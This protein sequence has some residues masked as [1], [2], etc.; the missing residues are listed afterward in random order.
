MRLKYI[1]ILIL[2]ALLVF[3]VVQMMRFESSIRE[4]RKVTLYV[5]DDKK[6]LITSLSE[7]EIRNAALK[8]EYYFMAGKDYFSQQLTRFKDGEKK[9]SWEDFF[10]KGVNLGVAVPGK[11]PGEFSLTFDEY[12]SWLK[13]IGEMNANVIRTY[14]ILPPAFYQAL[15]CYNFRHSD[16]P[17]YLMQGV[18]AE[19]PTDE[20]YYNP[21][22]TREFQKEIIDAV[23]VIHGKDVLKELPGKA[24][25]VYA[26][27]V[28]RYVVAILLGREWEPKS[29]FKTNQLNHVR[30]YKGEF[31][32][33]NEGNAVEAW[34]A[35][36]MDFTVLYETQTY[37]FQHPV[38]FVN[39]LPLDPMYHSTEIIENPKIREYDND[40]ESIDFSRFHA[41]E[42]FTPGIFAAYHAY[43]YYPDFVYL[44]PSYLEITGSDNRPDPYLGYLNDLKAH[45]PGMPL[46]IAEYGLPSSRGNSHFS[47]YGM[48]QGGHSEAEQAR[49]SL[50][51]TDDIVKSGCAGAVYFEWIDEWFKQNWLVMDFE[52]PAD[53]RRMWHN[54]ENPEQNFGILAMEDKK[55]KIDGKLN[56]WMPENQAGDKI[57]IMTDADVTYFYLA[58]NI[59]GL[60]FSRKNLYLALDTYDEEKGDHKLPFTKEKFDNG[61]EFLLEFKSADSAAILVD[62]P[63]SVYTDIYNDRIPGYASVKNENGVFIR[64]KMLTNRGRVS[65]LG[66]ITDSVAA[67]RSRLVHGISC[68]PEKSNADWYFNKEKGILEIR[69]DWHLINVTDPAKR[70]VLDN[71]P[72]TSDIEYV[73]SDAFNLFIFLTDKK[74]KLLLKYPE[75]APFSCTWDEWKTPK[76]SSRLKPVYYA[77]QRYFRKLNVPVVRDI[78]D[79]KLQESFSITDFMNGKKK[80]VSI[81][82]DN[83]GYSQYTYA[84]PILGKY[85]L[86]ATFGID[87]EMLKDAPGLVRRDD[88]GTLKRLGLSEVRE[89]AATNE[90]A[91]QF[92]GRAAVTAGAVPLLG[93][94]SHSAIRTMNG[95]RGIQF[96]ALPR[97]ILFYREKP[98]DGLLKSSFDGIPYTAI[99]AGMTVTSLD[100]ILSDEKDLWAILIYHHIYEQP[101]EIPRQVNAAINRKLFLPRAEMEKQI[102]LI[103]NRNYWIAPEGDVY[104]YLKEKKAATIRTER[105]KN[106]I[107]LKVNHSLDRD[108]YDLPLTIEYKTNARIIRIEGSLNDGTYQ[109]RNGFILF[110]VK[111]GNEVKIEIIE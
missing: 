104:R 21:G 29:V 12:L 32:C 6:P 71:K 94:R 4:G 107:F 40:L 49:L 44:Q 99:G 88:D 81:S 111:P 24:S 77:L 67:D 73:K 46:V 70:Y 63:Y 5:E 96:A 87:P 3:T 109:N 84:L 31:V 65:L 102:R 54:M 39:W 14:T 34:L 8:A 18:W 86:N 43:P 38:S 16:K 93:S 72:G 47:P 52:L 61:F 10:L 55:K 110:N 33:M 76:Y 51:L 90:I 103:R 17:I 50:T 7:E 23:N 9:S 95:G 53:D 25:G 41:T 36:M 79:K 80:A 30:Q 58:L 27:D 15:S 108:V 59:P 57:G 100:S 11:F 64:E 28:S 75:N 74:D 106:M 19:V 26:S 45:T 2:L 89:L 83:A 66:V 62:E 35:G 78:Q 68:D 42:L 1:V 48:N 98:E 56:D 97:S 13:L 101:N 85:Y 69:L 82:F 20:D 91:L 60:D 92:S 37:G 22:F 105:F